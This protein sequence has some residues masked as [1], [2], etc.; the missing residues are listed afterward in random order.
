MKKA[1]VVQGGKRF[2][3]RGTSL[4]E[5]IAYLGIAAIVI[6]G[7]ISLLTSAFGSANSN[8]TEQDISAIRTGVK[9]LYMGQSASYG[10]ES[11]NDSLIKAKVFPSSLTIDGTNVANTWNGAVDVDGIGSSFKIT[12]QEV[13]ED[14]CIN[15]VSI[16]NEW[17]SVEINDGGAMVPPVTPAQ[18]GSAC[19]QSSNKIV[20]TAN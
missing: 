14:V 12:Y 13:P 2:R 16:S 7:A 8:R 19:G 18:A 10:W 15:L 11:L 4:L 5:G 3:Q 1:N 9:R 6:V 20:W 17:L